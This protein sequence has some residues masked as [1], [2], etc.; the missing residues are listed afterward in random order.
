M[1]LTSTTIRRPVA[2]SPARPTAEVGWAK[3]AVAT[4]SLA[5]AAAVIVGTMEA[6]L[7]VGP[8]G[9]A[10]H[11]VYPFVTAALGLGSVLLAARSARQHGDHGWLRLL[12]AGGVGYTLNALVIAAVMYAV[13]PQ[14][15]AWPLT[16]LAWVE[17]WLWMP[18]DL[19]MFGLLVLVLPSGRRDR[20]ARGLAVVLAI[21]TGAGMLLNAF[22][23]PLMEN[24]ASVA[25]PLAIQ[26]LAPLGQLG[27]LAATL[28]LLVGLLA[29]LVR[30][31][32][33]L[34]RRDPAG[35][36]VARVGLPLAVVSLAVI[37]A[38]VALTGDDAGFVSHLLAGLAILAGGGAIAILGTRLT[39]R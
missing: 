8:G 27:D 12:A 26:A 24:T 17:G 9:A 36:R 15:R 3:P 2:P 14:G 22:A 16:A 28:S 33:L 25:N 37:G 30:H 34:V 19:L 5:G 6:V 20:I 35:R 7:P 18:F 10:T 29:G 23:Q 39:S 11:H 1:E 4:A 38:Q 21:I 13:T 32:A 31:I